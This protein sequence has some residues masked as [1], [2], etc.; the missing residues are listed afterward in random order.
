[1][2]YI[3][4]SKLSFQLFCCYRKCS[5]NVIFDFNFLQCINKQEKVLHIRRPN[6]SLNMNLKSLTG[7]N[8]GK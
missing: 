2:L 8:K 4:F 5:V 6:Y 3:K 7:V 1:M